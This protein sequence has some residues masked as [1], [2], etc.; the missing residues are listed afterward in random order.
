M[1]YILIVL[2]LLLTSTVYAETDCTM[3]HSDNAL[4]YNAVRIA[5]QYEG[6]TELTNKNDGPEITEWLSNTGLGSGY[7]YCAAF[8][9]SMYKES[10]DFLHIKN[11]T[12]PYR[13]ARVS[14]IYYYAKKN[15]FK[16]TVITPGQVKLG[17]HSLC[18]GDIPI[19]TRSAE[20]VENFNGHT[21]LVIEQVNQVEFKTIEAN[22][23]SSNK[24]DQG[25][26]G[27]VFYKTR[28]VDDPSFRLKGFIRL[29]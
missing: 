15:P 29:K 3:C 11:T 20:S 9:Y 12:L 2:A 21:G 18:E 24:G 16:Y 1:K 4:Q 19:W 13:S 27:G 26:G 8:T 28:Y 7:P 5:D 25:E 6:L 22:T 10:R 14:S 23:M 17:I